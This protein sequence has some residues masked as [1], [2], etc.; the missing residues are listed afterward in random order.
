MKKLLFF[1]FL[2]VAS[3]ATHAQQLSPKMYL[4]LRDSTDGVDVVFLQGK[5]GSM[6]VEG[7]NTR[8]FN[9]FIDYD[10]A[11]KPNT[12]QAASVMWVKQGREFISGSL[13]LGDSTG[14]VIFQKDGKE[15]YH[16]L[17]NGGN[18]FIKQAI[19]Q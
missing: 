6:N 5:G 9:S 3:L 11:S 19:K 2:I 15:Y 13:Y 14:C 1:S 10:A 17:N 12:Q 7:P 16:R 8:F 4:A 18:N